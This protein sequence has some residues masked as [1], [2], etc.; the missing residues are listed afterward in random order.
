MVSLPAGLSHMK[1]WRFLLF[2]FLGAGLWNMLLV[3]G[4][5]RL[6]PLIEKYETVAGWTIAGLF[7]LILLFYVY[8]VVTW[9]PRENREPRDPA[10][11]VDD[12]PN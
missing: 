1:L 10:G 8:R 9:T 6:A 4:G 3:E 5:R 11:S 12:Q 7:G 2:T